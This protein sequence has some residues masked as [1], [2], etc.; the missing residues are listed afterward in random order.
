MAQEE[1]RAH[2]GGRRQH[3]Q[4]LQ[5]LLFPHR[6]TP[7]YAEK[8]FRASENLCVQSQSPPTLHS[9]G[10]LCFVWRIGRFGISLWGKCLEKEIATGGWWLSAVCKSILVQ[11]YEACMNF[12]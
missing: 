7:P 10:G 3:C 6:F 4:Q 8:H 1:S 9:I 11:E 2:G 12:W 5:H